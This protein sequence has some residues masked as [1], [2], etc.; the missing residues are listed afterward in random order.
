MTGRNDPCPCG[1]GRKYK[2]CCQAADAA[3]AAAEPAAGV[4]PFR[5]GGRGLP[6]ELRAAAARE[7]SWSAD[8][9]PLMIGFEAGEAQRPVLLM[10]MAGEL[11]IHY[12]IRRRLG[13][14]AT[15]VASALERALNAAASAAG[16][17]PAT[18]L[19][20]HEPVAGALAPLLADRDVAVETGPTP[21]LDDAARNALEH[22][23]GFGGWPPACRAESW[24]SWE[25]PRALVADVFAAAAGFY[26]LAPWRDIANLQAPRA[27]LP[28]GREW[29]CCV[30]GNAGEEFGLALYAVATD[31]FE[32]VATAPPDE[33]FADVHGRIVSVTFD[34]PAEVDP[35]AMAEA[36]R[37]GW[38]VAG[39]A[40]FPSLMTVNTPGG[41]AARADVEDLVALLGALPRFVQAHSPELL[42]ED[43]TGEPLDPIDWTDPD[44]GILFR[45]AAEGVWSAPDG[46]RLLS[47]EL[48][49]ELAETLSQVADELGDAADEDTFM[50]AVNA[51][52][53]QRLATSNESP[54]P[55]LGGL[56]PVQV[57]R[58]LES[59][60]EDPDGAIRL[61]LDL[62]PDELARS[63]IL[64]N[65]RMLL[66]LAIERGGLG[67]TQK[68]NLKVEVIATLIQ[69]WQA[70]DSLVDFLVKRGKRITEQ[71]LDPLHRLRVVCKLAGLLR[72]R[73]Q[74]FEPTRKARDLADPERAGELFAL[75]FRTWFRKFNLAYGR[76]DAWP[77]LQQQAAF[78]LCRLLH[79]ADDWRTA[80][81]LLPEVVLPYALFRAPSDPG[82][83]G[84]LPARVLA[85]HMLDPLAGFGLLERHSPGRWPDARADRYRVTPLA[86]AFLGFEL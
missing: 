83:Y 48:R 41:G 33:P 15:D 74:R 31:L 84:D 60:W 55:E 52:L 70:D 4:L 76:Y 23:T 32:A 39:P 71:D 28:S 25:L 73:A 64:V 1:S 65:A 85:S 22:L 53:R 37:N 14:E 9:I 16:V 86:R 3:R 81:D 44:S 78:A 46:P 51:R 59:D 19:V 12:D 63:T 30:L 36:R 5:P 43:R 6:R 80:G 29:T 24:G 58:L 20:R 50:A 67:A 21:E 38:E 56:S 2:R 7:R 27:I 49:D 77:E 47:D 40:A 13:G 72:K 54:Q 62:T 26:R 75:L 66:L 68:G 34:P 8:A 61:R 17:L 69:Q 79:V 42:Y 82:R 57:R 35:A 10:V 45:Y 18:L 11:I